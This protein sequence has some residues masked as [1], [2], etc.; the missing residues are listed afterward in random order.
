MIDGIESAVAYQ[1]LYLIANLIRIPL[2]DNLGMSIH[3]RLIT[4]ALL[5]AYGLFAYNP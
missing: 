5:P 1:S 3:T 4:D 2:S